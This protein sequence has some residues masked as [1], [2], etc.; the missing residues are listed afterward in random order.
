MSNQEE[1]KYPS[2]FA[3]DAAFEFL[4]CKDQVKKTEEYVL[5]RLGLA[6]GG[7]VRLKSSTRLAPG[8][9]ASL[10]T[11]ACSLL[12]SGL[13]R[14]FSPD[15]APDEVYLDLRTWADYLAYKLAIQIDSYRLAHQLLM[16]FAIDYVPSEVQGI[17]DDECE[18]EE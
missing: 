17:E 6:Y 3:T 10:S 4:T 9:S 15:D 18:S 12:A 11:S 14:S 5:D 8:E 2:A 16:K 1:S 13:M 7:K